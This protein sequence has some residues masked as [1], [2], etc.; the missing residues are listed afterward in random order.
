MVVTQGN[1]MN[2][3]QAPLIDDV[4]KFMRCR[5]PASPGDSAAVPAPSA[6]SPGIAGLLRWHANLD[7]IRAIALGCDHAMC[8][9]D[10]QGPADTKG[11]VS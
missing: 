2:V 6:A 10:A 4:H 11:S 9:R 3:Q 1:R 8:K 7:G 5:S